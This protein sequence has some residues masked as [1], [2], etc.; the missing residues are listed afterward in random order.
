V[1]PTT[2]KVLSRCGIQCRKIIQYN[3]KCL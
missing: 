3:D 2:Q 1:Y